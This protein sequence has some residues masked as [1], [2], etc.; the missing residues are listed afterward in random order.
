[1][2]STEL[3]QRPGTDDDR[4]VSTTTPT[5]TRPQVWPTLL[6]IVVLLAPLVSPALTVNHTDTP[7]LAAA[8]L[9][10]FVAL[11]T[12][13]VWTAFCWPT[14]DP[15]EPGRPSRLRLGVL[16]ALAVLGVALA[17]WFSG[18]SSNWLTVLLYVG[19]SGG[20]TL[21][22]Q[23]WGV[24]W[25][26]ATVLT[27]VAVGALRNVSGDA[28]VA[29]ALTTAL[30]GVVI[31]MFRRMTDL[32]DHLRRT[33]AELAEV[34]VREERLRFSRDLHDLLGHT[35]SLIVVKAELL[36]RSIPRDPDA[37]VDEA[38]E[39]EDVGRRALTDVR[40]AVTG[41]RDLSFAEEL[42]SARKALTDLGIDVTVRTTGT[43]TTSLPE[44][45]DSLFG[46]VIR[47]A[48][49]NIVRHS[50]AG[51]CDIVVERKNGSAT[52]EVRDNGRA[53]QMPSIGEGLRGMTERLA[54]AGGHLEA[55]RSKNGGWRVVASFPVEA[56]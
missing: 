8:G 46:W 17:I 55:G 53:A 23:V 22:K 42:D 11:Y 6:W 13:V 54:A 45:A 41:Y 34:A 2:T 20:A 9:A 44:P 28:V 43:R 49:T 18:A 50:D 38:G 30:A 5:Q 31:I 24:R 37:A 51:R 10:V 36:R 48:T 52:L 15:A 32:I 47:E 3:R 19:V 26:V 14:D 16:A 1:M 29:M 56:A 40:E 7:G 21:P 25:L 12:T 39:I 4:R 33:Q 27:L 35:L